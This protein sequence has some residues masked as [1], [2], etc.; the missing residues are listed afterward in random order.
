[1]QLETADKVYEHSSQR[2]TDS[3]RK[4]LVD[5][6]GLEGPAALLHTFFKQLYDS[7]YD[8]PERFG[9]PQDADLSIAEVEVNAKEKKQEVKRRLDKPRGM[10][11]AG[12]DF[13]RLAGAQGSL[14]GQALEIDGGYAA[15]VKQSKIS[16]KFFGGLESVGMTLTVVKDCARLKNKLYPQ[17]MAGLRELARGCTAF[18]DA[19]MGK[20]QFA[21]CDFSLRPEPADLY[22]AFT[23]Q[24]Y[25]LVMKLHEFFSQKGY[26][27]TCEVNGSL[28]WVVKYQGSRKVK[29]TPLFQIDYDDRHARP[30]RMQIKC[31]SAQ[32]IAGLLPQQSQLLQYD[33]SQ[34]GYACRGDECGWCRNNK[35]LGPTEVTFN[36]E[37]RT[38]CWYVNPDI[39]EINEDT[40]ELVREY[41]QLHAQ[42]A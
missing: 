21:R 17:M 15:L 29:A 32:R 13:L 25:A 22:N 30:L 24:E 3:F 6:A 34:R 12:L 26:K 7:L 18:R 28:A 27:T 11:M 4:M 39:R 19:E 38:I 8:Q 9:L 2:V 37:T 23:G 5:P 16:K 33:F 31:A 1:M 14:E 41:E 35:T 20:F 36:G 40:V 42:L 10:I